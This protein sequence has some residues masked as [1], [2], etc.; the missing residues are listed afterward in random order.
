M[1]VFT[2]P[3]EDW[4]WCLYE[5][6]FFDALSQIPDSRVKRRIYCLHHAGTQ[7]PSP[8]AD[9]QSIPATPEHVEQWLTELFDNT[10][11]T[12]EVFSLDIS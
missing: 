3:D 12:K 8:I 4:G 6:G 11:Q 1:L 10:Q 5:T 9:L 2:D 7:P